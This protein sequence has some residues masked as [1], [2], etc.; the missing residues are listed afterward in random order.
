L[1]PALENSLAARYSSMASSDLPGSTSTNLET[2]PLLRETHSRTR[3]VQRS[4][5][6]DESAATGSKQR[7]IGMVTAFLMIFN[8]MIGTGCVNYSV[9]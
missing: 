3:D 1:F 2:T 8:Q 7:H 6:D 9:Y 4:S 5:L